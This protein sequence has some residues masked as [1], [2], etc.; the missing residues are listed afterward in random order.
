L[1][2]KLADEQKKA[3][4]NLSG[5][6]ALVT[7]GAG[8]LGPEHAVGLS[9]YGA[10]VILLDVVDD[11]LADARQRVL[12]Q[13]ESAHVETVTADITN[14][15]SLEKVRDDFENKGMPIDILVNNAALNP[16]M[17]N[18]ADGEKSGTVE[19]YD[20]M[21][22][23]N[24]IDVG[25]TGTFLCC[26]IFGGAMAVRGNGAIVNIASDLA[27]Q[28]PDQR[29]YSPTGLMEDVANFKPIGYPVV[30]AAML[31]LNRYLATYWAHRGVR[32]NVLIP[33]A[34]LNN[35]P[36]SLLKEVARRVPL[37]RW[38]DRKDYQEAVAFL[39]SDASS[40]MTGQELV[41]DG[42]RSIW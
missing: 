23:E 19:D 15:P 26:R 9:R 22:W 7:G 36:D 42:G 34:V 30:K 10:K 1:E 3:S 39:A 24:E 13:V 28:A 35:Q 21:L 31:G 37:G 27:I 11:G 17:M 12:D 4:L 41:M 40:Y 6:T 29:V 38:A 5:K 33:G 14:K 16:K 32:V 2:T 25:I 20:M 18:L 8:L